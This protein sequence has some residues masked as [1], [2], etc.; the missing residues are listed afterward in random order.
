MRGAC[1]TANMGCCS[2]N[3]LHELR[4]DHRERSLTPQHGGGDTRDLCNFI[5][6]KCKHAHV[7]LYTIPAFG[8]RRDVFTRLEKVGVSSGTGESTTWAAMSVI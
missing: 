7:I 1:R 5:E 3:P 2:S 4:E 6:R 8:M